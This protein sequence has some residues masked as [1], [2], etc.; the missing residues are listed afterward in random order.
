[1]NL[2]SGET[3]MTE[4]TPETPPSETAKP[5]QPTPVRS[6]RIARMAEAQTRI[7]DEAGKAPEPKPA[8]PPPLAPEQVYQ[9][10]PPRLRDLDAEIQQELDAA[11]GGL[12]DK[13]IYGAPSPEKRKAAPGAQQEGKKGKVVAVQGT[14]VF[15]DIP[16]GRSQG[17]LSLAQFP[18]G[19]P[20][21]GSE[22]DVH[23]EGYDRENG[24]LLLSRRGAAVHA[25]WSSIVEGMIVEAR[26]TEA[27]KGGLAVDVNGIRGFMPISQIDLYRVEN[28]EQFV[29][30]RL[31]CLVSEVN[32]QERNLVVSRRALMEK[33]REETREKLWQELAEGQIREGIVRSV[34]DFGAF[35]D[36]GGVDGLLHVS[37]MSWTRGQK[38]TDLVQLGQPIKVVVLKVDRD[39][40]KVSLGAKQLT[41]SPWDSAEVNY[42]LN[43]VVTGK[44][45]RLMDFGAFVELEPGLEGLVHISELAPQ[46][47]RRPADVV[48]PGQVVR[49]LVL[50][51]D[52]EQKRIS[53]SLKAIAPEGEEDL[54][55]EVEEPA[56]I[57]RERPRT[58][59]LRGGLGAE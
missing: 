50:G 2:P 21:V 35:V 53:L 43:S 16:G 10:G 17:V 55:G 8:P 46:R 32:P 29:N 51:I 5:V 34:K 3:S 41:P 52:R 14:D 47:V 19:A 38:A 27:N 4:N 31:R 56:E 11:M 23:I 44:V 9:A 13:E 45:T 39:R 48:Q 24:L 37:E 58:T 15:L 59:P 25:D 6:E 33:E 7:T 20:T 26:V 42:P 54:E 40:R 36:L 18:E 12:S 30:Q 1:M 22:V 57:P 28:A 49:I